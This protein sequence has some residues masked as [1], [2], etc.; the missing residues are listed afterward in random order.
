MMQWK[1]TGSAGETAQARMS[2]GLHQ[3]GGSHPSIHRH[4]SMPLLGFGLALLLTTLFAGGCAEDDDCPICPTN[5][6]N[7]SGILLYPETVTVGDTLQFWA[8]GRGS[9]MQFQWITTHGRFLETDQ[10]WARW[11]APASPV[12]ASVTLVAFNDDGSSTFTK[13]ITVSPYKPRHA[14]TYTGAAYCGLECHQ[15]DGHGSNYD[16]WVHSAHANAY[17]RQGESPETQGKCA[18]CHTVGY[19]DIDERGWDIHNGGFDEIPVPGLQG[20]QCEACHGPLANADGEILDEHGELAIGDFLIDTCKGCH[21]DDTIEWAEDIH[22]PQVQMLAGEGG[23]GYEQTIPSSPHQD[24]V[25]RG[26]VTCHYPTSGEEG[27]SHTFAADPT[28]CSACHPEASGIDLRMNEVADLLMLL[29]AELSQASEEDK[30]YYSYEWALRNATLVEKDGS[31]G[32]HN[33][34]YSKTLL[35]LSLQNFEP[36]GNMDRN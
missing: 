11:K 7:I 13:A 4:L 22:S 12:V 29:K 33:Y 23:Y 1:M 21:T 2:D 35:N 20:V 10:N 28:S 24:I 34:E 27:S 14:P 9:G 26:C 19:G 15:V 32:A 30:L 16:A 18:A 31:S 25:P 5:P 3:L 36:S 6:V 17:G 8:T